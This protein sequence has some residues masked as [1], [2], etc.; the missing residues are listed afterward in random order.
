MACACSSQDFI[1]DLFIGVIG[2][3][4]E[5]LLLLCLAMLAC[6]DQA[7]IEG[8]IEVVSDGVGDDGATRLGVEDLRGPNFFAFC[9]VGVE[10]AVCETHFASEQSSEEAGFDGLAFHEVVIS[11]HEDGAGGREM[12][13]GVEAQQIVRIDGFGDDDWHGTYLLLAKLMMDVKSAG[14]ALRWVL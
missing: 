11:A 10:D 9:A 2:E 5:C 4:L 14:I 13:D 12:L 7:F 6:A 3:C 8:G 1:F